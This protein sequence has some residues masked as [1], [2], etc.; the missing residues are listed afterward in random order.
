MRGR[1]IYRFSDHFG[2]T[3]I[4][5]FENRSEG[6]IY[7]QHYEEAKIWIFDRNTPPSLGPADQI[8]TNMI[9]DCRDQ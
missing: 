6:G 3:I 8:S 7:T 1:E 5:V 4:A 9:V 2:P